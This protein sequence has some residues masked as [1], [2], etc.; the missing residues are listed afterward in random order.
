VP[1]RYLRITGIFG[2]IGGLTLGFH[3]TQGWAEFAILIPV[4]DTTLIETEPG[5]N[6]GGA[7]IVNSGTTQNFTRNRGLF[8]FD[9]TDQIPPGSRITIADFVVEVTGEP[10]EEQRSSSFGLHRVLKPW[11]EGDKTSPDPIHPGLGAPATS[12]EAT[13]N[14]RFAFTTNTWTIPGGSAN[15]DYSP[16]LSAQTFVYG[17]GDSPYTFASTP[18]MVADVQAWV[19]DPAT[20]FGWML[21]CQSEETNFTARRFASREDA[22]REPYLVIEYAP[23]PGIDLLTVTNRMLNFSFAA[24]AGQ[25]YAVEF[26][27]SLSPSE[28]WSTLTNFTAQSASSSLIV[29]DAITDAQRFYRLRLP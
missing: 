21:L 3:A 13:W 18:R 26:R 14:H 1:A 28:P 20:N 29:S 5:N 2:L 4:A 15:S 8:R 9:F 11:G 12:G 22:G 6:L 10:K 23:P 17:L 24:Q 7:A 25:S 16:E 27:P 19:D